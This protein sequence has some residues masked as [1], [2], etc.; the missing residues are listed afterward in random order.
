MYFHRLFLINNFIFCRQTFEAFGT[1]KSVCHS[2]L[3][4]LPCDTKISVDDYGG[5]IDNGTDKTMTTDGGDDDD[6]KNFNKNDDNNGVGVSATQNPP[7]S[8][9]SQSNRQRSQTASYIAPILGDCELLYIPFDILYCSHGARINNPLSERLRLLKATVKPAS[10]QVPGNSGVCA[11]VQ[12]LIPEE[13]RFSGVLAS[14][15]ASTEEEINTAIENVRQRR[16]EGI[17]IKALDSLWKPN[18]RGPHW[19]KIKPDYLY[20]HEIDAVVLGGWYSKASGRSCAGITQYLMGLVK[21]VPS[22]DG[23]FMETKFITFCRVANGLDEEQRRSVNEKLMPISIADPFAKPS[24][25]ISTNGSGDRP[26]VWVKDP[27][28]SLVFELHADLRLIESVHFASRL[29]FRFPRIISIR[30]DK[31]AETA[32]HEDTLME[33]AEERMAK[34]LENDAEKAAPGGKKRRRAGIGKGGS[35]TRR[36]KANQVVAHVRQ[37][38]AKLAAVQAKTDILKGRIIYI[39]ALPSGYKNPP[40]L[41]GN[42]ASWQKVVKELGGK[43][44]LT[45]FKT[46]TDVVAATLN[47]PSVQNHIKAHPEKSILTPEWLLHCQEHGMLCPLRPRDFLY[48]APEDERKPSLDEADEFGDY[49]YEDAQ[50]EDVGALIQHHIHRENLDVDDVIRSLFAAAAPLLLQMETPS[51]SSA[52]NTIND[53]SDVFANGVTSLN[54]LEEYTTAIEKRCGGDGDARFSA[55]TL[56]GWL[57]SELAAVGKLNYSRSIL[58]GCTLFILEIPVLSSS[59]SRTSKGALSTSTG[60]GGGGGGGGGLSS[61]GGVKKEQGVQEEVEEKEMFTL[62]ATKE[63]EKSAAEVTAAACKLRFDRLKLTAQMHGAKVVDELTPEVTH[64]VGVVI[65]IS[66]SGGGGY[67]KVAISISDATAAAVMGPD[68][69]TLL[70]TLKKSSG[71]NGNKAVQVLHDS[72]VSAGTIELVSSDWIEEAAARAAAAMEEAAAAEAAGGGTSTTILPQPPDAAQYPL[73]DAEVMED[74]TAW[75]WTHYAP[76]P[77]RPSSAEARAGGSGSQRGAGAGA[78]ARGKGRSNTA[79]AGGGGE[80]IHVPA[81]RRGTAVQRGRANRNNRPGSSQLTAATAGAYYSGGRGGGGGGGGGHSLPTESEAA[82]DE[83]GSVAEFEMEDV[84]KVQ[85]KPR[86]KKNAATTAAS[87]AAGANRGTSKARSRTGTEAELP[88]LPSAVPAV[89]FAAAP[90]AAPAQIP[91]AV[92]VNNDDQILSMREY[93]DLM[94]MEEKEEIQ[95]PQI[96]SLAAQPAAAASGG[97]YNNNSFGGTDTAL[98]PIKIETDVPSVAAPPPAAAV[99]APAQ[100]PAAG[101]AGGGGGGAPKMSLKEKIRLMKEA[102]EKMQQQQ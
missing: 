12:P 68:S 40:G 30:E 46:V 32:N 10:V 77:K 3:E 37:H 57:D 67:N 41:K 38:A 47:D 25:V 65:T 39:F 81:T 92:E 13:T 56:L 4:G 79:A 49:Y 76:R 34:A 82:A 83:I 7:P 94:P 15:K 95:P 2:A 71:V 72:L 99:P 19:Q 59:S 29:S 21:K 35:G 20:K 53:S 98:P 78:G 24:S 28:K 96:S 48:M 17:V 1:I 97:G 45:N 22:E 87:A 90:S 36:F 86:A 55:R 73:M 5:V 88:P 100:Q 74:V 31:N 63:V 91:P 61:G 44:S 43:P 9:K 85:S 42:V 101:A 18:D 89:P 75:R 52:I 33:E 50:P 70:S 60:A 66:N 102:K 8:Q 84:P 54:K 27:F 62:T 93:F 23:E 6:G 26:D 80:I 14:K 69:D 16:E 51:S 58:H 11:R 64:L